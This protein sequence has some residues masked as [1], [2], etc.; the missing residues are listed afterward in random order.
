MIE[1]S[2]SQEVSKNNVIVLRRPTIFFLFSFNISI[3]K[4]VIYW[5]RNLLKNFEVSGKLKEQAFY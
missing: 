3:F 2:Y 4:K 1:R 5:L